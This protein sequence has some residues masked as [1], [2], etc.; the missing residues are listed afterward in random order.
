M[1]NYMDVQYKLYEQY[2][3]S[4]VLLKNERVFI[5]IYNFMKP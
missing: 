1:F 3:L 4:K 5:I 2:L